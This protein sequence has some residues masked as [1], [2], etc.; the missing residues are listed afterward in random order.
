MVGET[1]MLVPLLSTFGLVSLDQQA[2]VLCSG[3]VE[4]SSRQAL[5]PLRHPVDIFPNGLSPTY[6]LG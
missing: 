4:R 6:R 1:S 3:L 2:S 5:D